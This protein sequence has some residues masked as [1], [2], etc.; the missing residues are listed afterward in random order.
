MHS[1]VA[2]ESFLCYSL[3]TVVISSFAQ[4]LSI[5]VRLDQLEYDVE[6]MQGASSSPQGRM[7][8]QRR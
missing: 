7:S 6:V 4:K 8:S 5:H 3:A 1:S 2:K